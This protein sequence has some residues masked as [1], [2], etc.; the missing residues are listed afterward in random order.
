MITGGG[1]GWEARNPPQA[2]HH[3]EDA[4]TQRKPENQGVSRRFSLLSFSLRLRAISALNSEP[5]LDALSHGSRKALLRGILLDYNS[6]TTKKGAPP[7][8]RNGVA[9]K[10]RS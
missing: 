2:R 3:R 1:P 6:A 9:P 10:L 8:I 7:G 4:E 5:R